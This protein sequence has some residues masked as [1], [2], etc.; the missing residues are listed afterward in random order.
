MSRRRFD[1]AVLWAAGGF[2]L[3]NRL[4]LR[5][6][7]GG[8]AGWFLACYAIV[9]WTDLL[10]RWGR[11][12]PVRSWRQTL[13]LLMACGFLWEA[14]APLC[15]LGAV[16]DPWDFAAYQAGGAL[17]LAGQKRLPL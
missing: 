4:W 12:T 10:L 11:L 16:F 15:R 3:L 2:Y 1:W 17:W 14:A 7:L 9:A 5:P 13:P 8:P 6:T